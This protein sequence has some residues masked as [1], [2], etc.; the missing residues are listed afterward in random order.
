MDLRRWRAFFAHLRRRFVEDECPESAATLSYTTLV[1]VVPLSAVALAVLSIFPVFDQ[2]ADGIKAFAFRS[3]VPAAGET[4]ERYVSEFADQASRLSLAG[5][6]FLV[7]TALLLIWQI[8][9]VLNRIWRVRR[10]RPV[11]N[12]LVVYWAALTAGPPL[13]GASLALSS[14]LITLPLIEGATASVGGSRALLALL[15][16]LFEVVAFTLAF[17]VLPNRAVPWRPAFAGGLTAAVLFEIAKKGFVV[18]VTHFPAYELLYGALAV[19]PIFLAWIYVSW[20]VILFGASFAAALASFR[21][22][23]QLEGWDERL[24]FVLLYRL[25]GHLWRAQRQGRPLAFGELRELEPAVIE[26]RLDRLL[27]DLERARLIRSEVDGEWLLARD[28][29]EITLADLYRS[30]NLALP[31]PDELPASADGWNDAL[32]RVLE[33]LAEPLADGLATPLKELY[34]QGSAEAPAAEQDPEPS[35]PTTPAGGD[36]AGGRRRA[37]GSG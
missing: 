14:Y 12:R 37:T 11:V 21:P 2:L 4:I 19:V 25:V 36:P 1:A 30:A 15:P 16:F 20:L 23:A 9:Q 27:S 13:I 29:Q 33:T 22:R 10:P 32:R 17:V 28:P 18:Y 7:V 26:M 24:D 31:S 34:R 3:L 35:R 6:A 8:E 5:V